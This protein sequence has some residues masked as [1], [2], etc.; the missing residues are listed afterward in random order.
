M[1]RRV[2]IVWCNQLFYESVQALLNHP[3]I[4]V[5]GTSSEPG[6]AWTNIERLRPDT[7][8]VEECWSSSDTGREVLHIMESSAW[9]PRILRLGLHNN[10]LQMYHREHRTLEQAGDLLNLIQR[11]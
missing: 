2:F 1:G 5:V 7:V 3:D 4:E 8:I 6:T 9:D 11:G 10:E